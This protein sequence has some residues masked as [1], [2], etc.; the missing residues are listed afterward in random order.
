MSIHYPT[1]YRIDTGEIVQTGMFDCDEDFV[2]MNFAARVNYYGGGTHDFID[3]RADPESQYVITLP[4]G[5]I[6]TP[7]PILRVRV[8]KTTLVANG[9]DTIT[10]SGF[11]NPC[12]I[13][14]DYGEPEEESITVEGGGFV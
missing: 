11:P 10:L 6:I 3:A 13:I 9:T 4:E 8:S 5:A 12:T 14:K 2:E 1:I 7:R